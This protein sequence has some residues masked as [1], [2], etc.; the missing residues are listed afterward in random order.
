MVGFE[1]MIEH[2]TKVVII[3][4][5]KILDNLKKNITR[6]PKRK[7]N[8]YF[9]PETDNFSFFPNLIYRPAIIN[10]AGEIKSL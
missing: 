5:Y 8:Q 10:S 4:L 3:Y 6:P 2:S 1:N 9:L 7:N